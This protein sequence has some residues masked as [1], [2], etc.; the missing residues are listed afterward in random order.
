MVV[1][2]LKFLQL[3]AEL[4]NYFTLGC[5]AGVLGSCHLVQRF[6]CTRAVF[7]FIEPWQTD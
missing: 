6:S 3:V 1:K 4:S 7:L 5:F 2:R